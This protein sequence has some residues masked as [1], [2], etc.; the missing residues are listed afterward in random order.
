[1]ADT[2]LTEAGKILK[3]LRAS[4]GRG[5][6]GS[7][8]GN[9]VEGREIEEFLSQCDGRELVLALARAKK[10]VYRCQMTLQQMSA[11]SE[12]ERESAS[13]AG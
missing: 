12:R 7:L 1:M 3:T 6:G 11:A 8:L 9:P 13:T 10:E 4:K 2:G 5:P